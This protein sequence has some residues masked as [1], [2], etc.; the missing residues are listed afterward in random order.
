MNSKQL[1]L[2]E[3][4]LK[5][6]KEEL[7]RLINIDRV[8]NIE[9]LKAARAQGDLSEN[10]DYDAAREEQARIESR[11]KEV[12]N[13]IKNAKI[14]DSGTNNLGKTLTVFFEDENY[15]DSY[16]IVGTLESDPLKGKISNES[17][18]GAALLKAKE[19]QRLLIKTETDQYFVKVLKIK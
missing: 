16:T 17:P 7:D 11:I 14:I 8:K 19:G 13:I 10:A 15:E 18:L 4:G 3:E 5:K 2:T 6:Y 12:E 9:D 1:Q